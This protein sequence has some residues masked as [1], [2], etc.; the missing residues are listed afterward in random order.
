MTIG[1]KI[2]SEVLSYITSLTPEEILE[3]DD[4]ILYKASPTKSALCDECC[5]A[6]G[7]NC[8]FD[9][10]PFI[11]EDGIKDY[12]SSDESDW[13]IADYLKDNYPEAYND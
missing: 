7:G 1:E 3:L 10:C 12:L 8:T 11:E 6:Q 4:E 13:S 2:K 9:V 5:V